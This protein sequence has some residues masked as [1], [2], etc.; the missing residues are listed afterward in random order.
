MTLAEVSCCYKKTVEVAGNKEVNLHKTCDVIN[1]DVIV[2]F[3]LEYF[4]GLCA[5]LKSLKTDLLWESL[6][7]NP[8][9]YQ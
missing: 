1:A 6:L 7:H 2:T 4:S 9:K 8:G 5:L 3:N